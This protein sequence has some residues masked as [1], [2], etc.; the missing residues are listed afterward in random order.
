MDAPFTFQSRFSIQLKESQNVE[1]GQMTSRDA[2]VEAGDY[3]FSN[4][5]QR[6]RKMRL[7]V[8]RSKEGARRGRKSA[9]RRKLRCQMRYGGAPGPRALFHRINNTRSAGLNT[10]SGSGDARHSILHDK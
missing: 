10:R 2:C 7:I 5:E 4:H 9:S 3:L 8:D 6:F 1:M